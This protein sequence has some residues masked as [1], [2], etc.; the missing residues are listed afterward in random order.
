MNWAGSRG[1]GGADQVFRWTD[2][3]SAQ[4]W[5]GGKNKFRTHSAP[6][7]MPER[8]RTLRH[9]TLTLELTLRAP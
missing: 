4:Q 1:S 9:P 3:G 2:S 8:Y 5:R 7:A 6:R